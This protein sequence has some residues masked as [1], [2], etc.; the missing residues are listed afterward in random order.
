MSLLLTAT[1]VLCLLSACG[2]STSPSGESAGAPPTSPPPTSPPASRPPASVPPP[3]SPPASSPAPA[4]SALPEDLVVPPAGRDTVLTGTV[5]AGVEPGCL[6]LQASGVLHQLVGAV[7]GLAPG[8]R[9]TV[10]GR[11]D[12]GLLTT[13]QQGTPFV[14]AS[15]APA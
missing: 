1:T 6:L 13:C 9:A 10:R 2:G 8:Q 4:P 3:A 15:S 12:P 7:Q 14:V 11:P 5:E